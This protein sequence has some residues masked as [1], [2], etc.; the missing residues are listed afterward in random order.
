[1]SWEN[2]ILWGFD[3]AALIGLIL[4]LLASRKRYKEAVSSYKISQRAMKHRINVAERAAKK[5][6][7]RD[8]EQRGQSRTAVCK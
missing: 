2:A 6:R 1:M 8:E 3:A 5:E 4:I 7:R